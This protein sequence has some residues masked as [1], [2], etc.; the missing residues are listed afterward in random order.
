MKVGPSFTRPSRSQA[1]SL[2]RRVD[3]AASV[4]PPWPYVKRSFSAKQR[5]ANAKAK[6][7]ICHVLC[8]KAN[9]ETSII[10]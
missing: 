1:A 3:T 9:Y 2:L 10:T 4:M 5:T 8:K 7:Q 6:D